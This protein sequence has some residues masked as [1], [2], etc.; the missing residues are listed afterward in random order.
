MFVEEEG[1]CPDVTRLERFRLAPTIVPAF[2]GC[3]SRAAGS[4]SD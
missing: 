3:R 4:K 2:H 1:D